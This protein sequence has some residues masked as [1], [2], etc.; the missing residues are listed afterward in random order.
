MTRRLPSLRR[1]D[2][3]A[4]VLVGL[5]ILMTCGWIVLIESLPPAGRFE[6][7]VELASRLASGDLS[8]QR[9][10]D[11]SPL[12]L[13]SLALAERLRISLHVIPP[14]Q[15]LAAGLGA[16]LCALTARRLA[17]MTASLATLV[18]LLGS[19]AVVI[20]ATDFEP[21]TLILLLNSAGLFF[22]ARDPREIRGRD[23][24][25]GGLAFGLSAATRPAVLPAASL[26]GL[27]LLVG[28]ARSERRLPLRPALRLTMAAAT[29]LA[30]AVVANATVT[31]QATI[32]N[33]GTVF[34]EGTSP[35][36]TGYIL[37][38]PRVVAGVRET[39]DEPDP[40]H[41]AYRR[42][43]SAATGEAMD[44]AATNRYWTGKALTYVRAFPADALA[45]TARKLLFSI[46]SHGS[47]DLLTMIRRERQLRRFPGVPFGL[48][49]A[50][51]V[52]TLIARRD[53]PVL[54][55]WLFSASYLGL[56]ALFYVSSRQRNAVVPAIAI[57]AGLGVA[58]LV[59]E[60]RSRPR[61]S[62][63]LGTFAV[64]LALTL[65]RPYS[66]QR[67]DEH[68]TEA[69]LRSLQ[70]ERHA[71]LAAREGRTDEARRWRAIEET[72][73]VD[74]DRHVP[75]VSRRLLG[76]AARAQLDVD[77]DDQ[78]LFD[79]ALALAKANDWETAGRIFTALDRRGYVPR[80]GNAAVG[81]IAYYRALAELRTGSRQAALEHLSRARDEAPGE[82]EVLA[83][84]A[85]LDEDPGADRLL[86]TL[87]DPFTADLARA[88]AWIDVGDF[89]R[90][91][92]LL[93]RV[94]H[95]LPEWSRARHLAA[96]VRAGIDAR[97]EERKNPEARRPRRRD[98]S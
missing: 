87:H 94:T 41:S 91:E 46:H 71:A 50:L 69:A 89:R 55:L 13:W 98:L 43:A 79:L 17:G 11:V 76:A 40:L 64:V 84:S 63:L 59:E 75:T 57:L 39:I 36:A 92:A 97:E 26:F 2:R 3:G 33:P 5:A 70:A 25:L 35:D 32:M 74:E 6:K 90:A 80:R 37:L 85:V 62:A 38:E 81:S 83:L 78:R 88:R 1:A 73:L 66:P 9:L 14:L 19:H 54:A 27:A 47:W 30:L 72:W 60:W 52:V 20:N 96:W 29:P 10:T 24:V 8:R 58:T 4:L 56:M 15:I 61:R 53:P 21:E 42:V 44:A 48:L 82:A 68:Q 77:L 45:L 22:L 93:D 16:L 7:Y 86:E 65:T 23:W 34:Y 31:G 49:F 12:Y 51:A 95:A 18:G 28:L 67:E